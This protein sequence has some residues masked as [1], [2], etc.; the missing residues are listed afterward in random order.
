MSKQLHNPLIDTSVDE[1]LVQMATDE[2]HTWSIQ[3]DDQANWAIEKIH[4][5]RLDTKRSIDILKH[6]IDDLKVLIE[7]QEE[8]LADRTSFLIAALE[9]Y[10]NAVPDKKETKTEVQL[11]FPAGKLYKKKEQTVI[12]CDK[13]T[14][15]DWLL[16]DDVLKDFVEI[17]ES[18]KIDWASMKKTLEVCTEVFKDDE[19]GSEF[20]D[21]RHFIVNKQ[22]G[23]VVEIPGLKVEVKPENF[24]VK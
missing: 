19:L 18:K 11:K 12:T 2:D 15:A 9:E 1:I 7:R 13:E 4:E 17:V 14:A 24:D 21:V 10:F 6:K 16:E 8:R 5:E 23:E 3:D 20:D 22:T